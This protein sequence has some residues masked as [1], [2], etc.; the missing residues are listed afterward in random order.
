MRALLLG[1][2]GQLGHDLRRAHERSGG[3]VELT[4]ISREQLD[5]A[6]V[7][8]IRDVLSEI[9]FDV[10]VNCTSYHK[11]DEV[12]DNAAQAFAINAH[13]VQAM[14][15]VC[16]SKKARFIHVSTDYV[17]GGDMSRDRPLNE[18]APTAPVNIYGASKALGETLARL[19]CEDTIVLR[20]ASLFGVAGASGKGGNFVETMIRVG[21]EKGA[22]RVV[23]DQIMSPTSTAD[24]ADVVA[25]MLTHGC[26]AGLYHVVNTGAVSWFEFAREIISRAGVNAEV[27]PCSSADYPTRAMRPRYSALDNGRVARA[28]APMPPWQDALNRYLRAKGHAASHGL[29]AESAA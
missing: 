3:S 12:E 8:R 2:N 16:A 20:V 10:L 5:V 18:S 27:T 15:N 13:A 6:S 21:R 25:R 26:D 4:P 9:D 23:D 14:A 11:T 29:G 7:P 17:F 24:I 22:L 19:A 28:F 1:P